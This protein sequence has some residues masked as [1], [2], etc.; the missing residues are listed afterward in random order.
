MRDYLLLAIVFAGV[1]ISIFRPWIGILYY[2]WIG[3]MNPH[4]LTWGIANQFSVAQYIAIATLLGFLFC[5]DQKNLRLGLLGTLLVL[6]CVQFTLTTVTAVEPIAARLEWQRSAKIFLMTIVMIPLMRDPK[7]LRYLFMVV[8]GSLAF[9][10]VKGGIFTLR[11]GRGHVWGPENSFIYG[12]NEI[13]LALNMILPFLFFLGLYESRRWLRYLYFG[14]FFSSIFAVIGTNSRGA[15]LG[16]M[17]AMVATVTTCIFATNKR[18]IGIV[19]TVV[20]LAAGLQFASQEWMDR[21]STI[22]NYEEDGSAMGRINAWWVAYR[23]ALDRP[24]VGG[25]FGAFTPEMFYKYAPEPEDH[26]DVHSIYFEVLGEQGF[27]GLFIFTSILLVTFKTLLKL[28]RISRQIPGLEWMRKYALMLG[29]GIF[30]YMV[31]GLTLGL[32]YFDLFWLYISMTI[33]M[34]QI[35]EDHI[36]NLSQTQYA[37]TEMTNPAISA[38]T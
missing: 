36:N 32:A 34:K 12:N 13:G 37:V 19:L 10:G 31:N 15:L 2:Y 7:R 16:L 21:M 28:S 33:C 35:A 17:A 18:A 14:S 5:K 26:H 9:F 3:I 27:V 6:F 4:Q 24:F 25:G 23:L 29:C 1:P 8:V 38:V 30:S 20:C 11:G 22:E